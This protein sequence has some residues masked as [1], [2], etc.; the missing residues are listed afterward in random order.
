VAVVGDAVPDLILTNNTA[1]VVTPVVPPD[2]AVGM[3][4]APATITVGQTVTYTLN[5]TNLG[6]VWATNAALTNTLPANLSLAGV[7]APPG[8][9]YT[10]NGNVLIFNLGFMTNGQ[11]AVVTITATALSLGP[12]ANVGVVG[13]SLVDSNFA[14]NTAQ[15]VTA[16]VGPDMALGMTGSPSSVPVG[17]TVTYTLN[18]T[19]LGPV[20]AT[21]VAITNTLSAGLSL[22]G[23]SVP[24]GT[25][26]S[27]SQNVIIFN[28]GSMTNG[29]NAA[30][31][32]IATTLTVGKATN[33]AVVGDSLV[34]TSPANNSAKV[35]TT[36][37]AAPTLFSGLTVVPGVTGVF[38]T[39]NTADNATSQVD[40]GLST[41]SNASYLNPTL[42]NHH[43]VMLTGLMPDA[44][45]VFQVRSL[46]A[47]VA[48]ADVTNGSIVTILNGG[49][50][51]LY[52]T[53]GTFSTTSSLTF[54]TADANY[55]GN[56]WTI[57]S[58]ADGIFGSN[59]YAYVQGVGGNPTASAT[60][61]PNIPVAGLYDI[62]V[63]YPTKPGFFSASTPMIATG[64]TNAV[65]ASVNQTTNGGG[66]QPLVTGIYFAT[67]ATGN[68]AIYNDSGDPATSVV[69]NGA[70]WVYEMSQDT[71]TAA[72]GNVPAWWANFY[73]GGNVS[74]AAA[75]LNGYN[76]YA[77]YVLGI[78]PT[79]GSSQLQF[80]V[81]P[82]PSTNVTVAFAPWQGGRVYQLQS[83]GTLAN[84]AWVTLTNTPTVN[85]NDGSGFFTVGQTPATTVFYRLEASLLPTQ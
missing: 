58:L 27:A 28:L 31:S 59:N 19:N 2:M 25:T 7:T 3:T 65:L 23:V 29:Q 42:T 56:G 54:G 61:T 82:G 17:Q 55:A 44:N 11:T 84:P 50:A 40:F 53:N 74:G 35:A 5:V 81:T 18:V 13:D 14:N 38:I 85:T 64:T 80:V 68:L 60:Y 24:L 4:G 21:G 20:A 49:P 22:E 30:V 52:T 26:Y 9:T 76:Y 62:S 78:D 48:A 79:S 33:S 66:W 45:Y 43:V 36:I 57:G 16:V 1:Q 83:S 39:W 73:F 77:D 6:P 72:S 51:V 71:P 37:T 63:W 75:G 46:T 69:A 15:V 12:A 34:D 32:V 47:A 41:A 8:V 10:N 67:G 70:R